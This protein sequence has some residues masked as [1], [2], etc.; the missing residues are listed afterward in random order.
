[1]SYFSKFFCNFS[2]IS[3]DTGGSTRN[4]ASYCGL[5]GFKPTYGLV[6]R[7]G[8]IP[9]VNSMDV[10][11]ILTRNVDD[12]LTILNTIAGHDPKD[13]TTTDKEHRKIQLPLVEK[14]NMKNLK[15]GI[16]VEYHCKYLSDE[17]LETWNEVAKLLQENGA[18]IQQVILNKLEKIFIAIKEETFYNSLI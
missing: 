8:L 14:M 10:P 1:M 2:A 5:I 11:G 12:C 9:L 6:S 4:P 3:S 15:I 17:V 16:P 7:L 18:Q 13:S